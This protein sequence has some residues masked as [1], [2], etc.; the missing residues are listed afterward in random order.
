MVVDLAI[1]ISA[2]GW[3]GSFA[4]NHDEEKNNCLSWNQ[5]NWKLSFES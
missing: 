3:G 1:Y 2:V 4:V 5:L